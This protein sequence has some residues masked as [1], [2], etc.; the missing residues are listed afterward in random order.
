M[1]SKVVL[2]AS[3]VLA[4][5]HREPGESLVSGYVRHSETAI[6]MVNVAEVLS[7][8]QELGI[9][10]AEALSLLELL[11]IRIHDFDKLAALKVAEL[12]TLTK[13]HGLSLGD[14]ACLS[15]AKQLGCA[16]VTGDRAWSQLDL[17]IEVILIRE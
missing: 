9:P 13:A 5:L 1:T 10:S 6:S 2:D 8:Q 12:R 15:L 7:K 14:R 3:A 4:L 17:G 11:G 16:V